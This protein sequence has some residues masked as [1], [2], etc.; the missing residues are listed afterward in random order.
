MI[1]HSLEPK[2]KSLHCGMEPLHFNISTAVAAAAA[3]AAA[4][5]LLRCRPPDGVNFRR[6]SF[7]DHLRKLSSSAV[8]IWL[9]VAV[10]SIRDGQ[11]ADKKAIIGCVV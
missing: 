4:N 9:R 3:A 8:I 11:I 6:T 7:A 5:I 10:F 1:L 2:V